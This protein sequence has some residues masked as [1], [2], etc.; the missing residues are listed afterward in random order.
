[1]SAV[2]PPTSLD[3]LLTAIR[4][5]IR[6]EVPQNTY[7]GVYEYTIQNVTGQTVDVRPTD[8]TLSLPSM[9]N[10]PIFPSVMAEAVTG[11]PVGSI[12]LVRF[13]NADPSRP[14]VCSITSLSQ[15]A[16][17][18]ATDTLTFG[19]TSTTVVA[20]GGGSAPVARQGEQVATVVPLPA[21]PPTISGIINGTI[22]FTGTMVGLPPGVT[23]ILTGSFPGVMT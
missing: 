9:N 23:G 2:T 13:V 6:N 21:P 1:M 20:I 12:C 3:R 18:D 4:L 14:E 22:P 11:L 10:L 16:T 5:I 19:S 7:F 15:T 17:I 8:T